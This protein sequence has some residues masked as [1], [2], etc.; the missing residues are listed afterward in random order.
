VSVVVVV[1]FKL[2]IFQG[3]LESTCRPLARFQPLDGKTTA[4]IIFRVLLFRSDCSMMLKFV[5]YIV[6]SNRLSGYT[7]VLQLACAHRVDYSPRRWSRRSRKQ[8]LAT[9]RV[10]GCCG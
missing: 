7:A 5:I 6:S 8:S 2:S 4:G 3:G 9:G 1:G 10:H